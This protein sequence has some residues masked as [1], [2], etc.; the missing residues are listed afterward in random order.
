MLM[1]PVGG[2]IT[3]MSVVIIICAYLYCIYHSQHWLRGPHSGGEPAG[4]SK[5]PVTV[6]HHVALS[7]H[8]HGPLSALGTH[9]LDCKT[10]EMREV[11]YGVQ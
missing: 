7:S 11:E 5:V 4:G 2:P 8:L 10:H 1:W 6:G 3:H 9:L